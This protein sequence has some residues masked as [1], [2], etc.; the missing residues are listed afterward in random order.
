MKVAALQLCASDDPVANLAHTLSMV[1]QAS[2]AG[3][4][5]IATPEVTNC[6]SSSRRRQNEVLAL[7]EN[8]QTL[9]AMCTAAA[10]FG[11]W[12]SVGSLALKLPDDDRFTNRSFMID[13]SG[14]IVAQY[15][16]IHMFDV[17]LSETEQYRESDGY[18]AGDHAV[19]ADT[20]FGKIG[21]T[22]CYDI[23]FPH[24]YRGLA[25]SGASILLIPAAFAQPTGRAHWEV[26]LRARAIETGCYVIAAAQT[27]EHQTSQRRPRKTYGHSMIVSPWGEIM[28]DAGEDQG[29]IYADLDLSLVESTRA[30]VPSILSQQSFSEP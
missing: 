3:A 1:Q 2:E 25:K 30:R 22:I 28:A 11:V 15:D 26:L 10:R 14:Q 23:R 4:Q 18:R 16:K 24:L 20:A 7:Q 17:T 27:G 5:F 6:V 29:I 19:I 13:P 8:D 21:M 9:A 12:I